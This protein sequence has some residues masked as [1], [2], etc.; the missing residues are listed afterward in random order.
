MSSA[1]S[2]VSFEWAKWES[3]GREATEGREADIVADGGAD[4][5]SCTRCLDVPWGC[6]REWRET[7]ERGRALVPWRGVAG[8]D[9][10]EPE[11]VRL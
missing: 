10:H 2:A 4:L 11:G 8:A 1:G 3:E 9:E 5:L 7:S 6:K